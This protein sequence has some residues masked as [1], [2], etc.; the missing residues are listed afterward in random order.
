MSLDYL[1]RLCKND[2]CNKS[3]CHAR[4]LLFNRI[5]WWFF[6][7]FGQKEKWYIAWHGTGWL[8]EYV[9]SVL[10]PSLQQE[11]QVHLFS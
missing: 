2:T 1:E 6:W 10:Q 9:L 4:T 11:I 8:R 7:L 3:A 5:D